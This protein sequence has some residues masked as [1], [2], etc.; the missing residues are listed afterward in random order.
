MTFSRSG[1]ARVVA[2][3]V[4]LAA[5]ALLL[6][7]QQQQTGA[8]TPAS[9][10]AKPAAAAPD[11]A[12]PE[13]GCIDEEK[14]N[15]GPQSAAAKALAGAG[16][17]EAL[18]PAASGASAEPAVAIGWT[19][20]QL[21]R[22]FPKALLRVRG[23]HW[24]DFA[25]NVEFVV[26][27]RALFKVQF[28]EPGGTGEGIMMDAVSDVPEEAVVRSI[29]TSNPAFRTKAGVKPGMTVA[30]AVQ[31]AGPAT[32]YQEFGIGGADSMGE[33]LIF[34]GASPEDL[35]FARHQIV[36][37]LP[38]KP[39]KRQYLIGDPRASDRLAWNLHAGPNGANKCR[40][41]WTRDWRPNG[42]VRVVTLYKPD[43]RAAQ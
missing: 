33:Y 32:L 40:I 7:C 10:Q 1:F 6:A 15:D 21:R 9:T 17:I 42:V 43:S 14:Y 25:P 2:A 30:A 13:G 20:A 37:S 18:Y 38:A 5:P 19:F 28:D 34:G 31:A 27:G 22:K 12:K 35:I 16:V 11:P 24:V 29:E 4:V 3:T 23:S 8:P 26:A 39:G 41:Y 36:A